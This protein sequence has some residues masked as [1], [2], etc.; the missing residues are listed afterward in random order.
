MH[1]HTRID[2]KPIS[3]TYFDFRNVL[4]SDANLK[5]IIRLTLSPICISC[6]KQIMGCADLMGALPAAV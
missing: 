5:V 4:S 3:E 2:V 6:I 1:I